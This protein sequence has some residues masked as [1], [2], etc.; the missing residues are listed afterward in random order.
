MSKRLKRKSI[1]MVIIELI[2]VA[3]LGVFL[4]QMQVNISAGEQTA[5]L[6]K[7]IEPLQETLAEAKIEAEDHTTSYDAM[8]RSKAD[9]LAFMVQEKVDAKEPNDALMKEYK[10]LLNVTNAL[11]LDKEG[12]VVAK[13]EKS[14]ADFTYVR[15]NQ[16]RTVFTTKETSEPFEVEREDGTYR[17]YGAV[18]DDDRMAVIEQDPAELE[19]LL[20]DTVTWKSMLRNISVG[21][22]G[23]AFAVSEKD[24][25]FLYHPQEEV[26]GQDALDAGIHVEDLEDGNHTWMEIYGQRYLCAVADMGD[27][28]VICALPAQEIKDSCNITV[29]VV[30]CVFFAVIT[31]LVTYAIFIMKDQEEQAEGAAAYKKNGKFCFNKGVS[32]K[33]GAMIVAGVICVFVSSLYMQELFSLSNKSMSN[34]QHIEGLQATIQ[35]YEENVKMLEDQY[36]TRYLNKCRAAAHILTQKPEFRNREDLARLSKVLDVEF[37]SFFDETG[38]ITA[39]N[40]YYMNFKLSDNKEDQSY[41]FHKLLSGGEYLIQEAQEDEALGDYNQYIGVS[42]RNDDGLTEGFVQICV[43]PQ[44]LEHALEKLQIS[45]VLDGVQIGA[46]GFAF[47]LNKEDNTFAYYP[48][49][50]YIGREATEYGI[51]ENQIHDGFSDYLT[52]NSQKYFANCLETDK[53]YV[54]ACVPS[55]EIAAHKVP[56]ALIS[57]AVSLI[58]LLIISLLLC[59]DRE[60]KQT[61]DGEEKKSG[62]M[63]DVTMP[64]GKKKKTMDVSSR[65]SNAALHWDEK[66]PEQKMTTVLK[67]LLGIYAVLICIAYV[68]EK[69]SGGSGSMF[70][71]I[72]NGGWERGVNVFAATGCI[73][74][75]CIVMTLTI[76]VQEILRVLSNISSAQGETIFRLA[77]NFVKYA[78]VIALLYYCFALLGVD[79]GTLLAS[80]GIIGLMISLGAQKLVSDILAG[81]FIIFEGEFRVGDIV[82]IGDWR[83]TVVEIGIRTTKIEEAGGNMKVINNSAISGVIN[84]TRQYSFAACDFG[85]EYGES[86]ERVEYIL[87]EELPHMKERLP[88]IKN[89]PFYK[90]V[91]ELGDNSVNIKIVAQCAEGDRIQLMRD[92]NREVKLLFDKYE[93]NIPFPQVVLNQPAE[94]KKATQWQKEQAEKFAAEQKELAKQLEDEQ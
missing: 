49:E 33:L 22:T 50:K 65:W 23:F 93:I 64:D 16:L 88:A 92:L 80:A 56:I 87:K 53:Y 30:L 2:F 27:A 4:Y 57:T 63:F 62:S 13:A 37:I 28:Y 15:Y 9:T 68:A 18:I 59:L 10:T 36:D 89:G 52:I 41:E 17:Y 6:E 45:S 69:Q 58:C 73:F 66:T 55:N 34:S 24:Y 60:D 90:G 3:I 38:T 71:Y 21:S 32:T 78:S 86:L 91:S 54:F 51:K 8:Y 19:G 25:T 74:I 31:L 5:E 47:A 84:M 1:M 83:G 72:I 35:K 14:D 76:I 44:K 77:S 12:N 82:T 48:N 79:T 11:I 70:S 43:N 75:I 39:T 81:L 94:F 67:V 29:L 42:I 61:E 46:K 7:K 85:I 26:V 40:S 20:N